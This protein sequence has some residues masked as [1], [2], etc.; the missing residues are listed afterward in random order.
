[1]TIKSRGKTTKKMNNKGVYIL[2]NQIY[3]LI[4]TKRNKNEYIDVCIR[5]CTRKSQRE[6]KKYIFSYFR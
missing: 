6:N 2:L 5:M 1:M 3:I 4:L